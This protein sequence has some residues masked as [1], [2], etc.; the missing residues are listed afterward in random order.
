M[1]TIDILKELD[2]DEVNKDIGVDDLEVEASHTHTTASTANI[3]DCSSQSHWKRAKNDDTTL[4]DVMIRTCNALE[5]LVANFKQQMKREDRVVG[6]LEKLPN[7]SRLD[8]LKLSQIIINDPMKVKLFSNL[9]EDR[10]IEWV[11][12]LLQT[13]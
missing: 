1:L 9:G 2:Q 11:K 3:M 4:I 10:N 5:S 6:E 13:S 8:V 7:L 12:Q